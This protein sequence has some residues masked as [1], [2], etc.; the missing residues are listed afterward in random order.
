[1]KPRINI[2][3]KI[4]KN[5]GI[6][7]DTEDKSLRRFLFTVKPSV[8]KIIWVITGTKLVLICLVH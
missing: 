8:F 5:T 4:W 7:M 2:R 1:M 6:K 3:K